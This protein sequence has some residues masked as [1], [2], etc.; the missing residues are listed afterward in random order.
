MLGIAVILPFVAAATCSSIKIDHI[1]LS[2]PLS[3]GTMVL[4]CPPKSSPLDVCLGAR[5]CCSNNEIQDIAMYMLCGNSE[6]DGV[7]LAQV[8]YDM[9]IQIALCHFYGHSADNVQLQ[10]T[11]DASAIL[12]SLNGLD[13]QLRQ[14]QAIYL[15]L[16]II[17]G[18]IGLPIVL[19]FSIFPKKTIRN[20][21]FLNF[22]F[23]WILSSITFSI[24]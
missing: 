4:Q 15:A 12:D 8:Q 18:H 10:L 16:Q 11:P 22:C 21:I 7:W 6:P 19:I 3:N 1:P 20:L 9:N 2:A 23:T 13:K 17:G 5:G 14:K 24:G